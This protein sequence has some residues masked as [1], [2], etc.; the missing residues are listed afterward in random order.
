M[1]TDRQK[2]GGGTVADWHRERKRGKQRKPERGCE[3]Q[4]LVIVELLLR[5]KIIMSPTGICLSF[6]V[7]L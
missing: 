7:M 4:T 1:I 6:C 5:L 3:R 2:V